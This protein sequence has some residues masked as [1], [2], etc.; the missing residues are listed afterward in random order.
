MYISHETAWGKTIWEYQLNSSTTY[1]EGLGIGHC[2]AFLNLK[3]E[4]LIMPMVLYNSSKSQMIHL[5]QLTCQAPSSPSMGSH[6][7]G[8]PKYST[9]VFAW[10]FR[11]EQNQMCV[12]PY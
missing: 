10:D 4:V 3:Q 11:L 12:T 2:F 1:S 9:I 6:T 8:P 7:I 5:D